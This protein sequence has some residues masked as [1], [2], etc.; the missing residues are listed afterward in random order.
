MVAV[1]GITSLYY[2]MIIGWSLHYMFSSFTR[3]LPFASCSNKWNTPDCKLKLPTMTCEGS[4]KAD[5]G[6]CLD[7][8]SKE[9]GLWNKTLFTEATGRIL[10]SPSQEYWERFVLQFSSGIDQYGFPKWDLVLCLLL[11]WVICFLCLIKGIKTTGK[12][13]YFTALFPYV[14]LF[15]LLIR[16]VTLE[17]ASIGIKYFITP[18]FNRLADASVW[19]DAAN[20]VFFSMSIAG[21]GLITLSS[22]N[23]FHNNILRD[24]IIVAVG[25]SGTCILG[26]FVI[27]SYLGYMAG[28]LQVDIEDVAADG[29]GLAFVVYP[30][31]VSNLPPPT[32]WAILFFIMLLTLGLDSQFAM[33]ETVLSGVLD[34]Y[35]KLRPRKTF[36][37]LAICILL[38]I[39]GLPLTC[40]GGMYLLQLMDNYV[41]GMT[42]II[43]G[44]IEIIALVFI[45]GVNRF[46]RDIH[47]MTGSTH[48][49]FWKVTW[50]ILSPLVIAFI[51]IFMFV[52]Y[53]PSTYDKYTYPTW[54][55]VI[56]WLMTLACVIAI[57]IVMIIKISRES[58][59]KNIFQKIRLL[60]LPSI[61]WG[62]A[63]KKHRLLVNYVEGFQ[64]DPYKILQPRAAF[65]NY[66]F[67]N[68]TEAS[69]KSD[70]Q[71]SLG[72]SRIS[73]I[74]AAS[75]C[76]TA[77]AKSGMTYESNV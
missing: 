9:V 13:V 64:V 42:L 15:I 11:A 33:V 36:V 55:D 32:L 62:P 26:G 7:E 19:K 31:A 45:Y 72:A 27:F 24:S 66:G 29:A 18:N 34:Q 53:K 49:L 10:Q 12:V 17:N 28:Q 57:P 58:E 46:C 63:L 14:V 43:I 25:D 76:T 6:R 35:P 37:I 21:G 39:L 8:N 16:G 41:G 1:S 56:G 77:T 69:L 40:P 68:S 71:G 60:C 4:A 3:D 47:V 75:K 22:Y 44:F 38:F 67:D 30:E 74:S 54:A 52:D 50:R 48:F 20:Q 5:D 61:Y 2:N 51:F 70:N 65:V 23:R 73:I 59:G